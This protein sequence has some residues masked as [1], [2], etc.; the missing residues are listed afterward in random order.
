MTSWVRQKERINSHF[1]SW[2]KHSFFNCV[3]IEAIENLWK[4]LFLFRLHSSHEFQENKNIWHSDVFFWRAYEFVMDQSFYLLLKHRNNL[5]VPRNSSQQH[6]LTNVG[7]RTKCPAVT[8][9]KRGQSPE[10]MTETRCPI[11][12]CFVLQP[13]VT[14]A[15]SDIMSHDHSYSMWKPTKSAVLQPSHLWMCTFMLLCYQM[16]AFA[17]LQFTHFLSFFVLFSNFLI[18]DLQTL[19][20]GENCTFICLFFVY[21]VI[22]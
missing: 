8:D 13:G 21:S 14:S 15:S 7:G 2:P 4:G 19:H 18:T 20:Y 3:L 6:W 1:R 17:S 9:G 5:W 12:T 11:I 16:S 22:E 10:G